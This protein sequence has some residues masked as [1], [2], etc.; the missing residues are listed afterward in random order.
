MILQADCAWLRAQHPETGEAHVMPAYD[1]GLHAFD[2][3]CAC[4]PVDLGSHIEHNAWDGR[5]AYETGRR[6]PH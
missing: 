6:R 4:C 2:S 5:E 1:I 3:A